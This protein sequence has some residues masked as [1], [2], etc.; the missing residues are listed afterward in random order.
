MSERDNDFPAFDANDIALLSFACGHALAW[1]KDQGRSKYIEG[2]RAKYKAVHHKLWQILNAFE[3]RDEEGKLT[4]T[5]PEGDT[6][7]YVANAA[8]RRLAGKAARLR[9]KGS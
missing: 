4:S 1:Y 7:I 6:P 8:A 9:V 5:D 3:Y 2:E